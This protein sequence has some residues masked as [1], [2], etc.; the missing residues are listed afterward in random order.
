MKL[1]YNP[2][3]GSEIKDIYYKDKLY[4]NS[5]EN[6]SFKVEDI[7]KIEDEIADFICSLCGFVEEITLQKAKA[8][9]EAK[10]NNIFKCDKCN[11]STD[12][13]LKLRGHTLSHAKEA[14]ID[15]EL[16]IPIITAKTDENKTEVDTQKEIDAQGTREGLIGEGLEIE[17][18]KTGAKF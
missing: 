17:N 12:N 14:K 7:V 1:L 13:E 11:Y 6:Q 8:I 18:E 16:G 4:F 5:K 10:K 2:P 15:E 3:H 9:L